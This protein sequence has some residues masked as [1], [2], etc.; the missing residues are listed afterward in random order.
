M[1]EFALASAIGVLCPSATSTVASAEALYR[2]FRA[3]SSYRP[4]G[5]SSMN[6]PSCSEVAR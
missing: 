1:M 5:A 3:D 4:G 2:V 6:E